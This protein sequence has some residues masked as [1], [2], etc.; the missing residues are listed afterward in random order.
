VND[1]STDNTSN[2]V[3]DLI[4]KYGSNVKIRL[5]E[6]ENNRG[7]GF[8]VKQGILQSNGKTKIYIDADLPFKLNVVTEIKKKIDNGIDVVIGNR[9]DPQSE[10]V[11]VNPIRKVS[12][13]IY[14]AI[15]RILISG[16]ISDTQCGL[17]GFKDEIANFIFSR[18]TID[19][20]G[21]DVEVLRISQKH[22][23]AIARIPVQM[24]ENRANSRVH[25]I[26]DSIKMLWNL[27]EIIRNEM[28]GIYD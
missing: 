5:I 19:G 4:K 9:N 21:F 14:S 2:I 17:K 28:D 18:T 24:K 6:N 7:K 23:F 12:G 25:L 8:S 16:G 10:L 27:V 20:F 26:R 1:G 15:V 11:S 13:K 3:K 22:A